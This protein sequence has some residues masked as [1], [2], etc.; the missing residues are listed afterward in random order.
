MTRY[1]VYIP[2]P[3]AR[4]RTGLSVAMILPKSAIVGEPDASPTADYTLIY[5]EG[6]RNRAVNLVTLADRAEVAAGR[7]A[8]RYPTVAMTSAPTAALSRVGL[9]TPGHGIDV[10]HASDLRALARWL[11]L[12]DADRLDPEAV[13]RE[14]RL[15]RG[16]EPA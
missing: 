12:G 3:S 6:N 7:L 14:L 2:D 5:Y 15:S 4:A 13:A 11:E 9:F 1:P 10:S 8:E 16:G